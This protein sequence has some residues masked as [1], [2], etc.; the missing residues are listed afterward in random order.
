[1][2]T[3][4]QLNVIGLIRLQVNKEYGD[5]GTCVMGYNMYVNGRQLFRQPW[6]GSLSCEI[7]YDRVTDYLVEQGFNLSDITF[8]YGRID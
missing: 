4:N 5:K 6:Q 2:I 7:F 3:Q 1:M 8:D